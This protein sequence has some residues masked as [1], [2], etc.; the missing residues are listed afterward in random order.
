MCR[1]LSRPG[2]ARGSVRSC[3]PSSLSPR[4]A[5]LAGRLWLAPLLGKGCGEGVWDGMWG[6]VE[7]RRRRCCVLSFAETGPRT[8]KGTVST[9]GPMSTA[10]LL[11]ELVFSSPSGKRCQNTKWGPG[12]RCWEPDR[13]PVCTSTPRGPSWPKE[14]LLLFLKKQK[15]FWKFPS[16][17]SRTQNSL[18]WSLVMGS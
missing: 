12:V 5:P 3:L 10:Q 11:G 18:I 1:Q 9:K 14:E 4:T 16:H 15:F 2:C 7:S 13:P 8:A 6:H 17:H